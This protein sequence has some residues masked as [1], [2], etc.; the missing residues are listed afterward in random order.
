MSFDEV[1]LEHRGVIHFHYLLGAP[2]ADCHASM[3]RA[4]G[5][6]APVLRTV[7]NWYS[8]FA[9]GKQDLS[10]EPRCGRPSHDFLGEQIVSLLQEQP[11]LSTKAIASALLSTHQTVKRV[12]VETLHYRKLSTHWIP[13]TPSPDVLRQR[14]ASAHN[15]LAILQEAERTGFRFVFT[16]DESWFFLKTSTDLMWLPP[17]SSAPSCPRSTI[18]SEK[19]MVSIF[20]SG[21]GFRIVDALPKGDHMTA[22]HMLERILQPLEQSIVDQFRSIER[23]RV[24]IHMDNS[25]VHT[26]KI[27]KD[28]LS[29]SIFLELPHPPYSSDIAPSD[30]YLF[31]TVK[32]KLKGKVFESCDEL[33]ASINSELSKIS[34]DELLRVFLNWMDRLQRVITS[35]GRYL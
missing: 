17:G 28:F 13:Y 25:R 29:S 34:K 14:C 18:A 24:F 10:D 6:G 12:L 19:V 2:A 33:M 30:F 1:R 15:M 3:V 5:V 35:G 27:V 31:G 23:H 8:A 26:A 22:Q 9:A 16:G 21:A 4:Y 20:W 32:G 7:Q 11:S